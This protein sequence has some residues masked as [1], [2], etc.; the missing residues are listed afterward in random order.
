MK[1]FNNTKLFHNRKYIDCDYLRIRVYEFHMFSD[2]LEMHWNAAFSRSKPG[3]GMSNV[4]KRTK[5]ETETKIK[6]REEKKIP[7]WVDD[8]IGYVSS[9]N[10][11]Q[12][13]SNFCNSPFLVWSPSIG[14][15]WLADE[16]MS[17]IWLWKAAAA[18]AR[19]PS[20]GCQDEAASPGSLSSSLSSSSSFHTPQL[21][22]AAHLRVI[23]DRFTIANELTFLFHFI[24]PPPS[25]RTAFEPL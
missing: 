19:A 25:F 23:H 9:V 3:A 14:I 24:C 13:S 15:N 22:A 2:L 11:P 21:F 4:E 17:D 7:T 10:A 16:L 6:S 5:K 20:L 8:Q 12:A 18:A 1:N